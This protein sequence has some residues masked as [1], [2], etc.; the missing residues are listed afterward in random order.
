[1]AA[2]L[3]ILCVNLQPMRSVLGKGGFFYNHNSK[4]NFQK[5]LL[6]MLLNKKKIN[7]KIST[8]EVHIKKYLPETIALKTYIFLH[9]MSK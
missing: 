3:P 7:E 1:M 9:R 5:Q 2:G 4:K 8:Y 6:N